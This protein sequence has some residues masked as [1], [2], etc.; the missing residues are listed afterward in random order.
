[1]STPE[2]ALVSWRKSSHSAESGGCVEFA[3]VPG[4]VLV[5]DSKNPGGPTLTVPAAAWHDFL[6]IVTG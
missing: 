1:M 3:P 6:A 2:P 4:G 5:R